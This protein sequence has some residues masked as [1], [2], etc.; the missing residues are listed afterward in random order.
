MKIFKSMGVA[1]LVIVSFIL[2]IGAIIWC[3]IS[4]DRYRKTTEAIR[5]QKEVCDTIQ[6]AE[7]NFPMMISGFSKKELSKIHFYLQQGK[8]LVSDTVINFA[9]KDDGETQ[10]LKFPFKKFNAADKLIVNIGNRYYVLSGYRYQARYNYGMFGPVD[11][12]FCES[13]GFE[14]INGEPAGSGWLIKKYG[15]VDYQLPPWQ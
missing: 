13:K 6:K 4:W 3:Y 2:F 11:P 15:L 1:A 10:T 7:G 5:Y 8:L 14:K 12:C 9:A